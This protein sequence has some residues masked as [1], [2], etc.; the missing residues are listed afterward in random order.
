MMPEFNI[1]EMS[2]KIIL[3]KK[4]ASDIKGISGG[5]QAVDRNVDRILSSIAM[6]EKNVVD[7]YE[8]TKKE[9]GAI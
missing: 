7:A 8:V 6:L 2:K 9:S 3:L 1:E 4:T 5:I